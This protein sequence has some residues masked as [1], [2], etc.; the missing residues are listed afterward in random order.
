MKDSGHREAPPATGPAASRRG[1]RLLLLSADWQTRALTLAELQARG[2]DVL[3]L[4]GFTWGMKA[5]LQHGV[6]PSLVI[7]DVKGD[8]D[9]NP[10]RVRQLRRLLPGVPTVLVVGAFERSR[11]EPLRGEVDAF[12]VR[13][14]TV[15]E[16]ADVVEQVCNGVTG[17]K[18]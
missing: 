6:S 16:L 3:A 1:G 9:V 10:E 14:L 18:I 5:L 4:P 15:G 7:V 12:L 13:P 11:F 17:E 8:P 2:H